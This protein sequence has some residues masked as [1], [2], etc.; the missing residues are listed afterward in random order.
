[1]NQS[2]ATQRNAAR[3]K[4]E[5]AL[6]WDAIAQ[7]CLGASEWKHQSAANRASFRNLLKDVILRTAYSRMDKFWK[8]ATASIDKI[9]VKG[10]KAE[11]FAKFLS[12]GE[13]LKLSY[14]FHEQ[15]KK[16]KMN[17]VAYNGMR[18]SVNINDQI[19][20]FLREKNFNELLQKLRKRRDELVSDAK[21]DAR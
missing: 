16:W 3:G 15:G 12:N 7:A 17:D 10:G 19:D 11:V 6:D 1:V 18:Y 4:I 14:F 13:K 20:A 9:D 21:S 8:G 2:N 5:Q